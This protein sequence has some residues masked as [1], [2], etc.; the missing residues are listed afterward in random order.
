MALQGV[1]RTSCPRQE[2]HVDRK[3]A[4][5]NGFGYKGFDKRLHIWRSQKE[6]ASCVNKR[7]SIGWRTMHLQQVV[8]MTGS[9]DTG[10]PAET[11]LPSYT[12]FL[13]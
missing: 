1:V 4:E 13:Q 7:L 9:S 10:P 5:Q 12:I 8:V 11:A 2:K 3:E 6:K